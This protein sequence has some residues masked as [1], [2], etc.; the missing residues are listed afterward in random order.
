MF[1]MSTLELSVCIYMLA[2][3]LKCM[4]VDLIAWFC[5]LI[6]KHILF[7]YNPFTKGL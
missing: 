3:G 5:R 1:T 2:F 7:I 6:Q 4:V